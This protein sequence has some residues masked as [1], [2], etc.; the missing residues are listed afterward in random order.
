VL[1]N[2]DGCA[3][4]RSPAAKALGIKM[5][6]PWHL[7]RDRRE[8]H[9]VHWYSSNFAFYGD[10]SRRVFQVLAERVPQAEPYSIDETFLD[11]TGLPGDLY[12]RCRQIRADVLRIAKIPTCLGWG[13]SK[14]IAFYGVPS[15]TL[16]DEHPWAFAHES[17]THGLCSNQLGRSGLTCDL[18]RQVAAL[19]KRFVA[20]IYHAGRDRRSM[21][22]KAGVASLMRRMVCR[23]VLNS[24]ARADTPAPSLSRCATL[25][26]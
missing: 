10:I 8:M 2:N 7:I 21:P 1:S 5:G 15:S 13:P 19:L 9:G 25:L 4:A 16:S 17:R 14:V 18:Q 6:D 3:I 24:R 12:D 23:L 20:G 26:R 22:Y 11:L